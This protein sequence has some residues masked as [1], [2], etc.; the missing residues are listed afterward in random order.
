MSGSK[1]L[2]IALKKAGSFIK[3]ELPEIIGIEAINE[4]QEN[5]S[6]EN[7]G[8]KPWKDVKRRNLSSSWYDFEYVSKTKAQQ[9]P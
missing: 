7:F 8:G 9:P 4:F 2:E 3:N 6:K 1:D 5:F